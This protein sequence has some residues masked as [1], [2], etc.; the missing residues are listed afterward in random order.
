[1]NDRLLEP[2]LVPVRSNPSPN[3][4]TLS[5]INRSVADVIENIDSC[6]RWQVVVSMRVKVNK[7]SYAFNLGLFSD[8]LFGFFRNVF[9]ECP[10]RRRIVS[11]RGFRIRPDSML[12]TACA[13]TPAAIANSGTERFFSSLVFVNHPLRGVGPTDDSG[14]LS[15]T[16]SGLSPV[17]R[18][19]FPDTLAPKCPVGSQYGSS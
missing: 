17:G 16:L 7:F 11:W 15:R 10:S 1:M 13:D 9:P 19:P 12:Y 5:Y 4:C 14:S 2:E 18:R 6:N 8:L 3:V